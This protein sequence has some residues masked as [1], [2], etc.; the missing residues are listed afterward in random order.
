MKYLMWA[1]SVLPVALLL[2]APWTPE[3]LVFL[4]S[5]FSFWF[6][7]HEKLIND[8]LSY[9]ILVELLCTSVDTM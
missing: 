6:V 3:A 7:G 8:N 9:L 5:D 1:C 4:C 2:T